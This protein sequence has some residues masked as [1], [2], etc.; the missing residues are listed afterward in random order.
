MMF[1]SCTGRGVRK[2][3]RVWIP[4][5]V[6]VA[7][8]A[9]AATA[10]AV[11]DPQFDLAIERK[12]AGAA[13][14]E[15]GESAG[16]QIVAP[17]GVL[18]GVEL[19]PLRGTYTVVAA[20]DSILEGS[21]LA[22][23]FTADHSVAIALDESDDDGS[24]GDSPE[25]DDAEV[26]D[27]DAA[28]GDSDVETVIV[29]GTRLP[30]G[31]PAAVVYSYT[32]DEITARG[33]STTEE[34]FQAL[35]WSFG[36][37]TT[38]TNS[39][40]LGVDGDHAGDEVYSFGFGHGVSTINLRQL[41][42]ENTLV[43][44]NGHRIAGMA[45]HQDDFANILHVPLS[46]I[47]RVDIQLEGGSA[48]YG[49]DA[50][51]GIVNF[52]TKKRFQGFS[53]SYRQELSSTGAD[54]TRASLEGGYG[55]YSG[56]VTA[57]LS[58]RTSEPIINA[59]TGWTTMDLSG[60]LGPE[61]DLR[62]DH[63][64]QPGMTCE[65]NGRL[66]WFGCAWRSPRYQLPADHDGRNASVEDF[67]VD[68]ETDYY[69]RLNPEN[70][71]RSETNSLSVFVEQ[72][73]TDNLRVRLDYLYSELSSSQEYEDHGLFLVPK[74][75]AFNPF[76]RH[77]VVRYAPIYEIENGLMSQPSSQSS[78]RQQNINL[79]LTWQFADQQRL[80][81]ST[82]R[83]TSR[84]SANRVVIADRAR[85]PWDPGAV[86]F[87]EGLQS[88]DPDRAFN[89]FGNGTAQNPAFFDSLRGT[90]PTRGN[91]E[92]VA[93]N[94]SLRGRLF[95]M[96]GGAASYSVGG[97]Y[98][99]STIY[100]RQGSNWGNPARTGQF[101]G[102][103]YHVGSRR[104]TRDVG[105]YYGELSLP[106]FGPENARLGLH[107]LT[108]TL[109]AR[110]DFNSILV[111][112]GTAV[113]RSR[114]PLESPL[115][116]P[117]IGDFTLVTEEYPDEVHNPNLRK[118][119]HSRTSPR[120]GLVYE[121][122]DDLTL[123]MSWSRS[124][125]PPVWSDL[126]TNREARE[127]EWGFFDPFDPDGPSFVRV[128]ILDVDW[129]VDLENEHSDNY[130]VALQ[131]SP[132]WVPD[133]E[134]TVNWSMV[135][136]TNRIE[137]IA[138][139]YYSDREV[140][141]STPGIVHRD[142]RGDATFAYL[143]RINVAEKESEV[144][145]TRLTYF[146]R[147]DFGNFEAA[148][149]YS[150]IIEQYSRLAEGAPKINRV[151]TQDGSDR[152]NIQGSLRWT[153]GNAAADMYIYHTPSYVNDR[154]LLCQWVWLRCERRYQ[155]LEIEV[156]SLTTVDLSATYRFE[157]GLRLR[158]SGRNVLNRQAP[159]TIRWQYPYDPTRWNARG[160]VLSLEVKW[161]M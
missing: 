84:R 15:L 82:T 142:E 6:A 135:D 79:G 96:W 78:S 91:T 155:W 80:D 50:I 62:L 121:P 87:Y 134:W 93:V 23:Q 114:L 42:S 20:L 160:R 105:A 115:W 119:R 51:G 18:R 95:D 103:F 86:P 94:L 116:D 63:I 46:A 151:G 158:A 110:Y 71:A 147:T 74:T 47:E 154:A 145:N 90:S 89:V 99:E 128:P 131:W 44:I 60:M 48:V 1:R 159:D 34:L 57:T 97:E 161:E 59:K 64:G 35:P 30:N 146:F 49:S 140:F 19:G 38:Q 24:A 45:G 111:S 92:N 138:A 28:D 43:L 41:G 129:N 113:T 25:A 66:R 149:R 104:P 12:S 124:F 125:R 148:I 11:D 83:S 100:W 26:D 27:D 143:G 54:A 21:G 112:D 9:T 118:V 29:T 139:Y 117:D 108:L 122:I 14:M 150:W 77:M 22:Y 120:V 65:W 81:F 52:I 10:D 70:G 61:F 32:A 136:Y 16:I 4:L 156:G 31:D 69:D 56:N 13:L 75:N 3:I 72:S 39:I 133:L 68:D 5:G 123:R 2:Q 17:S 85:P 98:R 144:A 53:A 101:S 88:S 107:S 141:A 152:Y 36:S 153:K 126:G 58:R 33:V 40:P 67:R 132:V 7:V 157:N 102:S 127:R 76:G 137:H 8:A 109:Q 106:F 130:S 37:I 73:V 55:W